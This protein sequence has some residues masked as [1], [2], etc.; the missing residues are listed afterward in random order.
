MPLIT[1]S[2]RTAVF[3]RESPCKKLQERHNCLYSFIFRLCSKFVEDLTLLLFFMALTLERYDQFKNWFK[4]NQF[5]SKATSSFK[6]GKVYLKCITCLWETPIYPQGKY[7]N[8]GHLKSHLLTKSPTCSNGASQVEGPNQAVSDITMSLETD[9]SLSVR[10]KLDF[11]TF[12]RYLV[13]LSIT[14]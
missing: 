14:N 1:A 7:W 3:E 8:I 10:M 5:F 2:Q 13:G 12:A 6:G 4:T 11:F 9:D